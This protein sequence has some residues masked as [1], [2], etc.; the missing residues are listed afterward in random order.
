MSERP[1]ADLEMERMIAASF[2]AC[3][4][5]RLSPGFAAG[6]LEECGRIDRRRERFRTAKL[7]QA[8]F[9]AAAVAGSGLIVAG[10]RW[11]AWASDVLLLLTPFI[12]IG[13]ASSRR[14]F[15]AE[16]RLLRPRPL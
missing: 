2:A 14:L 13:L 15:T 9:G 7:V 16:E 8:V 3:P 10:L 1:D 5:P 4:K 12:F 11:P 6:I